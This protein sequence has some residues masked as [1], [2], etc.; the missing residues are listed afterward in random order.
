MCCVCLHKIE[1]CWQIAV[2][3]R[4]PSTWN[5]VRNELKIKCKTKIIK[6]SQIRFSVQLA[7]ARGGPQS[8][9][10]FR[11]SGSITA[12]TLWQ[13]YPQLKINLFLLFLFIQLNS[14]RPTILYRCIADRALKLA[15]YS[16]FT[17]PGAGFPSLLTF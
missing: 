9:H 2:D 15:G 10:M 11:S 5:S 14:K 1:T 13:R 3:R 16:F 4:C 7:L 6:Y 12:A 17:W 8:R